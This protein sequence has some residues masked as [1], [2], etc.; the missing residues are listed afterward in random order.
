[1]APGYEDTWSKV[2]VSISDIT[3]RKQMY[4]ARHDLE[5]RR[6]NFISITSHELRTPLTAIRGYVEILEHRLDEL[7][8][9][10]RGWCFQ[11]INRNIK[12]LERL[13]KGVSTLG[14]LERGIFRL[15][16]KVLDF[17]AFLAEAVQPYLTFLE[18]QLELRNFHEMVPT[19]IEADADRLLQV[20]DN[21]IENAVKNTPNESRKIIVIPKILPNAVRISISDNGAGI[22]LKDLNRIFKPFMSIPTKYS[23]GGTGI[24]LYLSRVLVEAHGGTLTAHSEGKDL[25]TTFVMELPRK[26]VDQQATEAA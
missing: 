19:L 15:D 17:F 2:I 11:S 21:L 13:I 23:V 12:R 20:L 8:Q 5:E 6:A 4:E 9:E 10:R 1:V 18:D 3:E 24:G 25:G 22:A 7:D 16:I 14:Q 26:G